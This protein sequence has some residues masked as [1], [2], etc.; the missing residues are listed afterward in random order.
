MPGSG[1]PCHSP[2]AFLSSGAITQVLFSAEAEL[3]VRVKRSAKVRVRQDSEA[4]IMQDE[5]E[6]QAREAAF[7]RAYPTVE[8][9]ERFIAEF[10]LRHPEMNLFSGGG[11]EEVGNFGVGEI[12]ARRRESF[13][14]M[15]MCCAIFSNAYASNELWYK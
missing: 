1:E 8:A 11:V 14:W 9:Q 7:V 3:S 4:A 2:L 12:A 5:Q 13:K 6:A 10:R 15:K